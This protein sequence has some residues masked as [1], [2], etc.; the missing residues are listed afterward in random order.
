MRVSE[1]GH[2]LDGDIVIGCVEVQIGRESPGGA[3]TE[4][5]PRCPTFEDQAPLEQAGAVEF[6][7]GVTLGDV[8]QRRATTPIAATH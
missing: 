5:A 6:D 2:H 3:R 8:Q 1:H 4:L 7:Q